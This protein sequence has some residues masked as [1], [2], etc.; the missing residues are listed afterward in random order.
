MTNPQIIMIILLVFEFFMCIRN[1]LNMKKVITIV[2]VFGSLI[3]ASLRIG[4]LVTILFYGGF[5]K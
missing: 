3:G 4:V 5:W 2:D 1:S